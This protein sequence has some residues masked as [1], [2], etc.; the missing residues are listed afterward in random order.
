MLKCRWITGSLFDL[1]MINASIKF[2]YNLSAGCGQLLLGMVT[3]QAAPREIRRF[4]RT[5]QRLAGLA[6]YGRRSWSLPTLPV[7][8]VIWINCEQGPVPTIMNRGGALPRSCV[9]RACIGAFRTNVLSRSAGVLLCGGI[10]VLNHLLMPP[11]S[12]YQPRWGIGVVVSIGESRGI[13]LLKL[14]H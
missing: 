9:R 8:A 13:S 7:L 11:I 6:A 10:C 3:A 2:F 5:G 4:C 14:P 1:S 12:C